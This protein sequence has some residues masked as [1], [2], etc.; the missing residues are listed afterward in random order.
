MP[1]KLKNPAKYI[2]VLKNRLE[3]AALWTETLR[4][5]LRIAQGTPWFTYADDVVKTAVLE[6]DM[7]RK[8]HVEDEVIIRGKIISFEPEGDRYKVTFTLKDVRAN[9][10]E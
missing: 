3:N 4:D 1:K 7:A 5:R 6:A 8:F 10:K 9:R 2:R